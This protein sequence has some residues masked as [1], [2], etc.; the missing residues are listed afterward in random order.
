MKRILHAIAHASRQLFRH[1]GSFLIL[2]ALDLVML[3]AIYQFIATRE[4]TVAQLFLSLLL[5]L[6]APVLFLVI[7]TMAAR[8]NQGK[9]C[10]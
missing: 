9:L 8:Y 7:Q 1:W 10:F 3:G 4:A 6:L 2:F 5:A